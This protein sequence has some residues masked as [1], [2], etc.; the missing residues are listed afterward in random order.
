MHDL[1]VLS[2]GASPRDRKYLRRQF[3]CVAE[4]EERVSLQNH[5]SCRAKVVAASTRWPPIIARR[6]N[7]QRLPV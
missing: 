6:R 4:P 2:C 1:G 3:G 7:A 5:R